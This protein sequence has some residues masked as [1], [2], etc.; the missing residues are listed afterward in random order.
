MSDL[1]NILNKKDPVKTV[2]KVKR[3]NI[4]D[5]L[6]LVDSESKKIS[7]NWNKLSK[8]KKKKLISEFI[9][10]QTHSNNLSIE[11]NGNL[12]KLILFEFNNNNIN[13]N[14]DVIYDSNKDTLESIKLLVY[15]KKTNKYSFIKKISKSSTKSKSNIERILK[16]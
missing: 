2:T 13:K 4:N 16:F 5:I 14:S 6:S 9:K 11:E 1:K 8:S 10:K 3:S 7:T 15:D 12:T